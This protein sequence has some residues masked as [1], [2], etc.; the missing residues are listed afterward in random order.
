[1]N[2]DRWVDER[3]DPARATEA[4]AAFLGDLY[5]R[6]GTW[7]LSMGA[8]NMGHAGMLRS[9]RKYNSNDFWQ[10]S[11]Y[12][13]GL[14]WETSLYVPKI[15]ALAIVMNNKR[16]FGLDA[17]A[18]DPPISFDTVYVDPGVSLDDVA[19]ASGV[20][21]ESLR[22]MNP[23]YLSGRVPPV[24][25]GKTAKPWPVRV[26]KGSGAKAASTLKQ[27]KHGG[28]FRTTVVRFGDTIGSVAARWQ[29]SEK[30]LAALNGLKSDERL[31]EGTVLLVPAVSDAPRTEAAQV[32]VVPPR[33]AA[34]A[35]R[36]RVFYR[37][38][39]GDTVESIAHALSVSAQEIVAWNGLDPNAKLQSEMSLQVFVPK[40]LDLARVRTLTESSTRVLEA[41]SVDFV[42][43]FEAQNGR[44]RIVVSAK[45]GENLAGIG[46]RYGLSVG[47]MERINRV[48]RAQKLAEGEPIIVY[49]KDTEKDV[50]VTRGKPLA[51][52]EPPRPDALPKAK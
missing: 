9:M 21:K 41:G 3:L 8:Y 45:A 5:Q 16:A 25:E 49:V 4:A 17:I 13:A 33:S 44:K 7:E 27:G 22:S 18:V 43:H 1:L 39:D 38:L 35:G 37:V 32:V 29:A 51:R 52:L 24:V 34:L 48:P 2:G 11:R 36:R 46:K 50:D 15:F 31:V 28:Q 12:E 23:Q 47:M 6:F 26:P 14:P 19:E 10:L 40:A 20:P 30:A 42:Q